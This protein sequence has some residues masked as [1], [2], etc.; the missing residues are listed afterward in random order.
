MGLS[1][2]E[3]LVRRG[4][5]VY[6]V[7]RT[8]RHWKQAKNR[9]SK[10]SNFVLSLLDVT[11]ESSVKRYIKQVVKKEGGIDLLINNAGYANRPRRV[12]KETAREFQKNLSSN[13]LSIFF[14]CKYALPF[15]LRRRSGWIVNISSMAGKR[16]VPGLSAYSASKSGVLA[17]SQSIAKE[18]P[19]A[20]FK[21]ITICPGGMNTPMRQKLF[22]KEDASRQQSTHFVA[23]TLLEIFDG[24]IPVQ[25]GEDVVIRHGQ[26]TAIN[27]LPGR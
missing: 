5:T 21:C 9:I 7:T 15:F 2:A 4:D 23:D 10:N 12:E 14:M 13:L 19:G 6:G 27:P 17:L 16:A 18:N 8:R 1:L 11:S 22:G 24:K 26:I 25:S 20:R 3:R